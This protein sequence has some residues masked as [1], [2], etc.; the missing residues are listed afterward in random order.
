MSIVD[1]YTTRRYQHVIRGI[2]TN[3]HR[4]NDLAFI[5][6]GWVY[7]PHDVQRLI[8]NFVRRILLQEFD[9]WKYNLWSVNRDIVAKVN[10]ESLR[11]MGLVINMLLITDGSA[12]LQYTT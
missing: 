10:L 4:R 9:E 2:V 3:I 5:A 12:C 8:V 7:L 11:N 6:A 1:Y